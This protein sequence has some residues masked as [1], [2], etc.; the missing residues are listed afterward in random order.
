MIDAIM[1]RIL[2]HERC[3]NWLKSTACHQRADAALASPAR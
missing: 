2:N 1:I 3:W